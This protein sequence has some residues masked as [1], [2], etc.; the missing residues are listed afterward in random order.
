[1]MYIY[2]KNRVKQIIDL[3]LEFVSKQNSGEK[4]SFSS[5]YLLEHEGYKAAVYVRANDILQ[6]KSWNQKLVN[7]GEIAVKMNRA[8]RVRG[9]NF[10]DWRSIDKFQKAAQERPVEASQA[11]YDLFKGADDVAALEGIVSFMGTRNYDLIST[12]FYMKDPD[13]YYPCKPRFFRDAFRQLCMDTDCFNSCTYENYTRFND[14]I[15][16]LAEFFSDYAGHIGILDAHSF[17]WIIGAYEDARKYI[18]EE[19]TTQDSEKQEGTAQVK[20]RLRQS[21][22]RK[23]LIEYWEG[24]CA[25]TGCGF[26]DVLIAS[27]AKPW[28]KC[29]TH[30]ESISKYNGFLLTPNIDGLFD[31]GYISFDDEG[32][33][34]ISGE[35]PEKEWVSLG[36]SSDM[37]LDKIEEGHRQF[38]AYHRENVFKG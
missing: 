34:L 16:E 11:V 29:G 28:I 1:M 4:A 37:K 25:V 35:V 38:L 21:E 14:G 22:Y 31:D 2:D 18:F 3:F 8:M 15:R 10:T 23:N 20:V 33:I 30:N 32:K 12:M 36:L 13:L 24:K 9:N 27:H 19:R 6:P 5:G 17:A 7:S 26:T